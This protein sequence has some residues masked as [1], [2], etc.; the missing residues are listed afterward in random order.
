MRTCGSAP[1]PSWPAALSSSDAAGVAER[2]LDPRRDGRAARPD[3]VDRRALVVERLPGAR[4]LA[5]LDQQLRLVVRRD[6]DPHRLP[7][8]HEAGD[9]IV[10]PAQR[11]P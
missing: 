2:P 4:E 9:G 1:G 11:F 3:V 8:A 10:E 5:E 6:R 7:V